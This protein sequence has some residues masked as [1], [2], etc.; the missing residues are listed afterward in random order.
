MHNEVTVSSKGQVMIPAA[1]RRQAGL[2]AGDRLRVRWERGRVV[3]EAAGAKHDIDALRT[4][5]RK[6]YS[7]RDLARELE[8]ERR[9][10]Y[11]REEA[12]RP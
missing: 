9:R 7:G 1:V 10:D 5:V 8:E 6:R 12:R 2:R 11:E 3:M 4:A